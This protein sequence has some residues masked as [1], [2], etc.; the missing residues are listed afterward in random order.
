MV[1]GLQGDV[2][3]DELAIF[4]LGLGKTMY[5]IF[6]LLETHL[7]LLWFTYLFCLNVLTIAN[8]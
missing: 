1:G 7:F 5:G 4:L 2:D 6:P 8:V 3:V